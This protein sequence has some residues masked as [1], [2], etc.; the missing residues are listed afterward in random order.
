MRAKEAKEKSGEP[1]E[2]KNVRKNCARNPKPTVDNMR[3]H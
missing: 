3:K 2:E 1:V